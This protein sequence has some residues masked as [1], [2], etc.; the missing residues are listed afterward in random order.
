MGGVFFRKDY[1]GSPVKTAGAF[2]CLMYAFLTWTITW[3]TSLHVSHLSHD[4]VHTF[5]LV[6]MSLLVLGFFCFLGGLQAQ[7]TV[8]WESVI[9]GVQLLL[10]H[11][12]R[13]EG[14]PI[15]PVQSEPGWGVSAALPQICVSVITERLKECFWCLAAELVLL[16]PCVAWYPSN[17]VIHLHLILYLHTL[18]AEDL[19]CTVTWAIT[20]LLM[21]LHVAPA[22]IC[23]C[24][25]FDPVFQAPVGDRLSSFLLPKQFSSALLQLVMSSSIETRSSAEREFVGNSRIMSHYTPGF[26]LGSIMHSMDI[27]IISPASSQLE[28]LLP[29]EPSSFIVA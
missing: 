11:H 15:W 12:G 13:T 22:S 14:S 18:Y 2:C 23:L 8:T 17:C 29:S 26:S 7:K 16:C 24:R 9:S 10:R 4:L 20:S 21:S 28:P 27:L 1:S 5:D 3:L 6:L 19:T 25:S